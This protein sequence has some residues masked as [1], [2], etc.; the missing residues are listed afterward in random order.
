[1]MWKSNCQGEPE[2]L[3][4][5]QHLDLPLAN[6]YSRDVQNKK[7]RLEDVVL[8][9]TSVGS[10][11]LSTHV[12]PAGS[13]LNFLRPALP[14]ARELGATREKGKHHEKWGDKET[15]CWALSLLLT[16]LLINI[17]GFIWKVWG[18]PRH[19]FVIFL[20]LHSLTF[21]SKQELATLLALDES[22]LQ[23]SVTDFKTEVTLHR[24]ETEKS[25]LQ[26]RKCSCQIPVP[27]T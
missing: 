8:L 11:D 6:C 23:I 14:V 19:E 20:L 15:A 27:I 5:L 22:L 24:V 26:M 9:I 17:T 25:K 16:G 7:K 18:L 4:T 13:S 1:M 3:W 21:Q 10:T 12:Q 2:S